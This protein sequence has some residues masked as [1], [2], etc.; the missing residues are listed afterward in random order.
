[1]VWLQLALA[2]T[3]A[4]HIDG[5]GP[6][7]QS[8]SLRIYYVGRPVGWERYS[9]TTQPTEVTLDA[10]FDYIDRGRRIHT[11]ATSTMAADYTPRHLQVTRVND[12]TRTVSARVDVDA[13]GNRATVTRNGAT[14][15]VDLPKQVFALAQYTPVSQHLALVR[16]WRA[17]G[18]PRAL[19][20]IPGAPT[21]AVVIRKAGIDTIALSGRGPVSLTRYTLDGIVWG[22]EYLWLDRE[23]RI[24]MFSSAGGGL[25]TKGIRADLVPA[26]DELLTMAARVAVRDLA[27]VSAR[28]KPIAVSS[29]AGARPIALVGATLIDGTGASPIENST[30]VVSNGRITASGPSANTKVPANARRIDVRGKSIIPG[31]WDSHAH[32]HQLEWLPVYIA[33]GVT[34]VRDMGNEL[35]FI[36]A[37]RD[38]ERAGTVRGPHIYAAGLVDGPGPN[39][40]G[41]LSASTP[42]EGRAI[43]RRYHALGFEQMKLYSLLSPAVVAAIADEAHRSG[44]KVTGHIPNSLTVT[45]A[46]DSGM[47]Q[48]AHMP[49]RGSP[50]SDTLAQVLAH[51]KAK[52]IVLDPTMSWNEIG[53][54]STAEP[55][56]NFQPVTKHLPET[57]LQFRAAGWGA[58]VDTAT[59]QARLARSLATLRAAHEAGI[60]I[61]V[62]TDEGVPG[63][64][65]YRE[66]ELY[67]M[68]GFT[69]MEAL[70]SATSVAARAMGVDGVVGTLAVGKTADLLVLD[71]NPIDNISNVRRLGLV[72]RNGSLYESAALWRAAGFR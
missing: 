33:A 53:G 35:A 44:M 58:N 21:N 15:T 38:A 34:S 13:S 56:D 42:G 25:E 20:V 55:L 8:D 4:S 14:A 61:I 65:V 60:P 32:L 63:F 27:A 5:Q 54:H 71:A 69:P 64:S 18:S 31:L 12:T 29:G 67:V 16:Y 41:A 36:T 23:D 57:F 2:L 70:M 10:D 40:F 28:A 37:L 26:A 51:L 19:A 24:A 17:H 9:L 7:R 30:I 39:A 68:A 59:A 3:A 6:I 11:I 66:M 45:S 43:V 47:D 1:M 49:L 46:V 52:G 62:G 22:T 50:R 48:I 72:M